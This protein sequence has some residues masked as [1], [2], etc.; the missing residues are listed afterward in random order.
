MNKFW[1]SFIF[2]CKKSL[3]LAKIEEPTTSFMSITLSATCYKGVTKGKIDLETLGSMEVMDSWPHTHSHTSTI[4]PSSC[5]YYIYSFPLIKQHI[6][7]FI[8]YFKTKHFFGPMIPQP[9]II[10]FIWNLQ[11]AWDIAWDRIL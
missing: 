4:I 5:C 7:Q 10:F 9:I 6:E 2:A 1:K 8:H 3:D 11:I